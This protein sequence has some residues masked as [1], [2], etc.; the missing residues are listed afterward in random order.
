MDVRDHDIFEFELHALAERED[1]GD[2]G[3][4]DPYCLE[5]VQADGFVDQSTTSAADGQVADD[6][7]RGSG[8]P[9]GGELIVGLRRGDHRAF[10]AAPD[11][12]HAPVQQRELAELVVREGDDPAGVDQH[13]CATDPPNRVG[14]RPRAVVVGGRIDVDDGAEVQWCTR[15]DR[16]LVVPA[17]P[18]RGTLEPLAHAL[19]RAE[20]LHP[21]GR[22]IGRHRR[23]CAG[24]HLR[25]VV[26]DVVRA[27]GVDEDRLGQPSVRAVPI[28]QS[29]GLGQ[30]H[31]V[32][33]AEGT[34]RG[35]AA[36]V[37]LRRDVVE[38]GG[39][40]R[41]RTLAVLRVAAGRQHDRRHDDPRDDETAR[42]SG[43]RAM[44]EI[45]HVPEVIGSAAALP[46]IVVQLGGIEVLTSTDD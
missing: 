29:W 43:G 22:A 37:A 30:A 6:G 2:L 39:G 33:L 24:G 14:P 16:L 4:G 27:V 3:V 11:E 7:L 19:R 20:H 28:A 41:V 13:R 1:A 9:H 42:A 25:H 40:I 26:G 21:P 12:R 15:A 5:L 38:R 35:G 23:W 31:V 45:Q 8:Q 32:G 46:A 44:A 18:E 17:F 36:A 34:A 10:D